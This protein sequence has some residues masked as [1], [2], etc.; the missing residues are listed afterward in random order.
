MCVYIYIYIYCTVFY[1]YYIHTYICIY[2]YICLIIYYV[3]CLSRLGR[4]GVREAE[5]AD[6]AVP[7]RRLMITTTTTVY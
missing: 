3:Y 6:V 4:L 5:E 7:D 1:V 2:I